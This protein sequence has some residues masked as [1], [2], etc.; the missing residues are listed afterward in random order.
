MAY[1]IKINEEIKT[2]KRAIIIDMPTPFTP[3]ANLI[4]GGTRKLRAALAKKIAHKILKD[5]SPNHPDFIEITSDKESGKI[6]IEQIRDLKKFAYLKPYKSASKL[7]LIEKGENLTL[8]AQNSFLKLLEEPPHQTF[9]ILT[10]PHKKSLLPTIV[11]R[12]REIKL[13]ADVDIEFDSKDYKRS[14]QDFIILLNSNLGD[15]LAWVEDN[16]S[17]I[18]NPES[19]KSLLDIW[20]SL[21][22]DLLLIKSGV[23]QEILNKEFLDKLINLQDNFSPGQLLR[24]LKVVVKGDK[25]IKSTPVDK[26]LLIEVLLLKISILPQDSTARGLT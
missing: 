17:T 24:C 14:V 22:R 25:I 26:R 23:T 4:T 19:V 6:G 15:R 11:S 3:H 18:N 7:I 10:A 16:L 5:D 13:K 8:E 21:L 20:I 12:C 9:F 2:Y 1:G